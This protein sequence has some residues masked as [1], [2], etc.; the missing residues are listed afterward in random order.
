MK[1][2]NYVISLVQLDLQDFTTHAQS[3]M[4]QYGVHCIRHILRYK[5][6]KN[7]KVAYLTPNAVLNA[8]FPKDYEYYTKVAI[9]IGGQLVTLTVN[10]DIPLNRRYECGVEVTE[11]QAGVIS[12]IDPFRYTDGFYWASHYRNGYFVGEMYSMGG[13]FNEAGYFRLDHEMKQF[14]FY[15]IPSTEIVLEYVADEET[16]GSTLIYGKDVDVLRAYIHW[17]MVN[18]DRK[19]NGGEKQRL[20]GL[21]NAAFAERVYIEFAPNMSDYLDAMYSTTLSGPK[22]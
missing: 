16:S 8:P 15:N 9:N 21:Y 3:R 19:I 12:D 17:Q 22:R 13:G 14:Q 6:N 1:N 7:V 20:M 5:T 2:L 11:Q 18:Y 4:L 10:N